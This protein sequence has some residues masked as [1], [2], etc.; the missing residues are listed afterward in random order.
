MERAQQAVE[1]IKDEYLEH[2]RVNLSTFK[3]EM[4]DSGSTAEGLKVIDPDEFDVMLVVEVQKLPGFVNIKLQPGR[5]ILPDANGFY[6]VTFEEKQVPGIMY[7]KLVRSSWPYLLK[8]EENGF[9]P[10]PV[11]L[12]TRKEENQ[13]N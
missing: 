1:N 8:W 7:Y 4:V 5:E 12:I 3:V 11:L 6:F 13:D 2:I 10:I 9:L